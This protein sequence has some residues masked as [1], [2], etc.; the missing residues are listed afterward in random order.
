MYYFAI[1]SLEQPGLFLGNSQGLKQASSLKK[2]QES[3]CDPLPNF[4]DQL[5]NKGV[6]S[7]ACN[8]HE[9]GWMGEIL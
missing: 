5:G 3:V 8:S 7:F 1:D 9:W 4:G 2:N 6:R